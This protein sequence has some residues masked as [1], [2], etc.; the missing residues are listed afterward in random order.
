VRTREKPFRDIEIAHRTV[1]VCHLGNLAY[2]LGRP[3]KW[4]PVKEE[5]VGDP[6]ASRWLDRPSA[7][8]GRLKTGLWFMVYGSGSRYAATNKKFET[9]RYVPEMRMICLAT[10]GAP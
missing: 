1:T 3:L 4:D 10:G 6:E 5:I 8:R 9:I 7:R 2:R